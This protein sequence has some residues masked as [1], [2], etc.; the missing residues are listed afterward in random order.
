MSSKNIS[1]V[2]RRRKVRYRI[3]LN[4]RY[5]TIGQT[6]RIAGIAR[7][8]DISSGGALLSSQH[9]IVAGTRV[10]ISME[11]PFLLDGSTP[12]Q[13]SGKGTVVR[14][15]GRNFAVE[16]KTVQFRTLKRRIEQRLPSVSGIVTG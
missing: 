12:L 6:E 11:W 9:E 3:E 15:Q 14:C 7:T 2:E 4:A 16:L 13:L 8:C 5:R 1:A 10:E